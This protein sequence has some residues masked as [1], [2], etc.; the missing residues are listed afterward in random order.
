VRATF[1]VELTSIPFLPVVL[2]S[3]LTQEVTMRC[4]G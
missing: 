3:T 1:P 2:P 4:G